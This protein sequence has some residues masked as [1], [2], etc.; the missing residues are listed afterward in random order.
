M[1]ITILNPEQATKLLHYWGMFAAVCY[2]TQTDTPEKIGKHCLKSGHFSGSRSQYIIFKIEDCP[3]DTVDQLVRHEQG[4]CK[5]VRSFR[6]VNMEDFNCTIPSEIKD[7]RKLVAM[8]HL[9]MQNTR[10]LYTAIENYV[11][12]KTKSHERANEQARKCLPIHTDTAVC[13]G[14]DVEAL[15]HLAHKRL[16]TRTEEE[17]NTLTR[18]IVAHASAIIPELKP[19]LVCQCDH[20]GWCPEAKGCGRKPSKAMLDAIVK[21]HY[22]GKSN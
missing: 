9:N 12:E 5:N 7:N 10:A 16:C 15:I 19:Y 8:W 3:R 13:I 18:A 4:C 2:N 17:L 6:Y 21:E 20:L 1:R 14:M 22:N 11:Y